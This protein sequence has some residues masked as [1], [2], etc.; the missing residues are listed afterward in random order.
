[1]FKIGDEVTR[2]SYNN[3][4]IFIIV[5]FKENIY[6]LKGKYVRL[7]VDAYEEDLKKSGILVIGRTQ[8][9]VLIDTKIL[10]V[11]PTIERKY[12]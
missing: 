12:L 2:I 1:M 6:Y 10:H 8:Q 7:Y 5:D 11:N 3:D 4:I 9:H